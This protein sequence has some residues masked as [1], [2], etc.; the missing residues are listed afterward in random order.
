MVEM[1]DKTTRVKRRQ[2][3]MHVL[4]TSTIQAFVHESTE[5][6]LKLETSYSSC[7]YTLTAGKKFRVLWDRSEKLNARFHDL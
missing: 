6:K 5:E 1:A 4:S 2:I 7:S 3:V